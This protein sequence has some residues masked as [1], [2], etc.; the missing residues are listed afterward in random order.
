LVDGDGVLQPYFDK[1]GLFMSCVFSAPV[2]IN[3]MVVTV[4]GYIIV[5]QLA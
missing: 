4:R 1:H 2:M 5:V 3:V